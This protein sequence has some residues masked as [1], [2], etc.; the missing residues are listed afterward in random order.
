MC[1]RIIVLQPT[2]SKEFEVSSTP[3]PEYPVQDAHKAADRFRLSIRTSMLSEFRDSSGA[4]GA[5][6]LSHHYTSLGAL[7][8]TLARLPGI[9][10]DTAQN[11]LWSA[12]PNRF[13]FKERVFELSIPIADIRIA[14]AEAGAAC[15]ETEELLLLVAG[16]LV[17]KWKLRGRPRFS[18]T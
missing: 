8:T 3:R 14:P 4:L 17:S 12:H 5:F 18:R 11:S 9:R 2:A 1:L 6:E 7:C 16:E 15:R 10:L 13:T